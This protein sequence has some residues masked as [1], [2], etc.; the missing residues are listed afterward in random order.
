MP[1]GA[2]GYEEEGSVR[3]VSL[4]TGAAGFIASHLCERLLAEGHHVIGVDAFTD[5]YALSQKRGNAR[6]LLA[7]PEFEL[8]EGHL[9]ELDLRPLFERADYLFHLAARAGVREGWTPVN[10][11]RYLRDNSFSTQRLADAAVGASRLKL[12]VFSS[13]SSIYGF[14]PILPTPEDHPLS[15]VSF[16]AMTKVMDEHLLRA[17][18]RLYGV[19]MAILRYYTLFGP[20]QRPDMLAHIALRALAEDRPITIYGDGEQSRELTYVLDAVDANLRALDV[21]PVGETFNIGSGP[22]VT[23][24]EFIRTMEAVTGKRA[25]LVYADRNPA[26]QLHSQA[27]ISK[28]RRILGF[29]P[30]TTVRAGLEAEYAWL[31][32][33]LLLRT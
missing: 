6:V 12:F 23:V 22:V 33:E 9:T 20:R 18:H 28:A 7:Q 17:Y 1:D 13:T 8:I 21:L 19:P 30:T 32:R 24:N 15:P 31:R 16:Y 3:P 25:R 4:V 5:S 10:F 26:D 29:N 14:N 11:T 2:S 27:D